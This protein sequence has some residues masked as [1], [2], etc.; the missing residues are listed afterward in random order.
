MATSADLV[1]DSSVALALIIPEH[2][3]R[4]AALARTRGLNLGLSGHAVFET[5][6][7]LTRLPPPH[8]LS[9]HVARIVIERDFPAT[10]HLDPDSAIRALSRLESSGIVGG[11]VYDG[12]VALAAA[13]HQVLLL[14]ADRRAAATYA[15]LGIAFELLAFGA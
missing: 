8:R 3:A 15:S 1:L 14:S 10:V 12:L 7:V 4:L 9:A 13:S 11:A 6:S 5:F 2:E